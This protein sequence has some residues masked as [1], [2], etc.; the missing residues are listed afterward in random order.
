MLYNNVNIEVIAYEEPPIS[1]SSS[2]IENRLAPIYDKLRLPAGRLELMSGIKERKFWTPGTLPSDA[3]TLAGKKALEQLEIPIE[4]IKCLIN[5]SVCR[6]F[7]EP[8][9]AT[10]VHHNLNLPQDSMVFDISNACLGVLTGMMTLA[11]MIELGQVEAGILVA[12]ENAGSL[13]ESTINL[14]LNDESINRKTIKPLFASLTIGSGAVA[15]VMTNK[16]ISKTNH[17]LVGAVPLAATQYNDLCRGN[18]DKGMSDDATTIMNTDSETLMH[19]GIETAAKNWEM[20]KKELSW[21]ADDIDC[22][23]THQVGK[24]HKS[25]LVENLGLNYDNDFETL[26]SWGN[27][28]SV[29]CPLTLAVAVENGKVN[30]GDNV[31]LLGI[32]SG[33]N[34]AMLGVNW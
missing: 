20:F 13:V 1:L 15:V 26:E 10:V 14:I 24:A 22:T 3:A 12:G 34:S 25:M 28:G 11:N 19:K 5:C 27:V 29:S 18:T 16:N 7:L 31:A 17:R 21:T 32:G 4:K 33:I 30:K 6:D 9:T 2:D 8:A 23:C